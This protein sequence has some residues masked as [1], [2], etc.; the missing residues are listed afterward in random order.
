M[1]FSLEA[2]VKDD[3]KLKIIVICGLCLIGIL[4]VLSLF[5][6][7]EEQT[8][9]K[10]VQTVT[11]EEYAARLEKKVV[12]MVSQIEGAGNVQVMLTLESGTETVY[13]SDKKEQTDTNTTDGES[14]YTRDLQE[15]IV[16]IEGEN[17]RKQALVKTE[18]P[19][20]VQ[21]VVVVCD[22]A[23]NSLVQKRITDAVTTAFS[24][25]SARVAVVKKAQDRSSR[26]N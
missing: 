14:D 20:A 6:K 24:I 4:F 19:P 9:T 13:Q 5:P 18:K 25:S 15:T 1:W 3:K 17:G 11:T 10:A 7:E 22:G 23:E 2:L 16:L 8:K 12:E 21:G 26:S